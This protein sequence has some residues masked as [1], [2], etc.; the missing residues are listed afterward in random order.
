MSI[1]QENNFYIFSCPYCECYI[2][3]HKNSVNCQIFRHGVYKSSGQQIN[4]HS[5]KKICDELV[6]KNLVYG[7]CKPFRLI[8]DN[9]GIVNDIEKCDYI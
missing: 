7:C 5:S 4:P 3:V 9:N 8:L 6:E 1:I 2:Q